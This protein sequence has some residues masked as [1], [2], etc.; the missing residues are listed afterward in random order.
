M[1]GKYLMVCGHC[2]GTVQ[3]P[4]EGMLQGF[5]IDW[6]TDQHVGHLTADEII[7]VIDRVTWA[8]MHA[9]RFVPT[10]PFLQHA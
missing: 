6:F 2:R 1:T 3:L 7:V 9:V 10:D 4:A 5:A 8:C